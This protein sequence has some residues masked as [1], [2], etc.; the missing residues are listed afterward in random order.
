[1]KHY[2]LFDSIASGGMG[3]VHYGRSTSGSGLSRVVAI[4]RMHGD[5]RQRP[6]VPFAMFKGRAAWLATRVR[7]PGQPSSPPS[8]DMVEQDRELLAWSWNTCR[9]KAFKI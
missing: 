8:L 7:H 1:M 6:G 5:L 2:H 9:A 4:K 3:T